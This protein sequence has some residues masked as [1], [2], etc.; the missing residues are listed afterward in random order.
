MTGMPRGPLE[1]LDDVAIDL[2]DRVAK[3]RRVDLELPEPV[4]GDTDKFLIDMVAQ[5]RW[6]RKNGKG[7]YDYPQGEA[8]RLWSGLAEM[9]PVKISRSTPE[10]VEHIKQRLLYRQAVEAARCM[11]ENVVTAA[12]DADVGAI[13][14]WGFA[15]WTGGPISLIDSVGV[16]DFTK[17]CEALAEQYGSRFAPPALLKTMSEKNERFYMAPKPLA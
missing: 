7:V 9:Y 16:E 3:Q 15:P 12:R 10:L 8:K 13:L 14:G 6:G 2:V 1:L 11:D 17:A 5:E 4:A